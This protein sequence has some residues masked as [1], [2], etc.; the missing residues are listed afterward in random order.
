MA[1]LALAVVL[2]HG[3]IRIGPTT[4]VCKVGVPCD[5]PAAKI[6]LRFTRFGST[7]SA[8]TDARGRYSVAL[9]PGIWTVRASVGMSIRPTRFTPPHRRSAARDFLIDTGIR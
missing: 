3:V 4:P 2:L 5:K 1:A 7:V 6:V 8:T 9:A